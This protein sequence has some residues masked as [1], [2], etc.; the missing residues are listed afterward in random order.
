MSLQAVQHLWRPDVAEMALNPAQQFAP[1]VLPGWNCTPYDVQTRGITWL[2]SCPRSILGDVTGLGKTI[3]IFGLVALLHHTGE[4]RGQKA[5]V[6][7]EAVGQHL[8]E[9]R[10]F[11]P[12]IRAA[13]I[14]PGMN[15][16]ERRRIY[17]GEWDVLVIGYH[18]M[19]RDADIITNLSPGL[20]WFDE[21]TAF[22]NDETA[23]ANGARI[24]ATNARR[25]HL[26]TATPVMLGLKDFYSQLR[27]IGLAGYQGSLFGDWWSFERNF[28]TVAYNQTRGK[29][30]RPVTTTSW[31]A[32]PATLPTFKAR[33][34]SFYLRRTEG[35]ADMPAVLPPD[36]VWCNPT[37]A[38][39]DRLAQIIN[40]ADEGAVRWQLLFKG[41][42]TIAAIGGPDESGKFDRFMADLPIRFA[43]PDGRPEKIVVYLRHLASVAALERRLIAAGI[44][45]AT[46]TGPNKATRDAVRHRFWEDDSCRVVIGTGAIEKSLNL[47]VARHVAALDLVSNPSR[48]EQLLGRVRR[49]GSDHTHVTFTRYLLWGSPEER[50]LRLA[51]ERQGLADYIHGDMSSLFVRLAPADQ[52][53]VLGAAA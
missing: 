15:K 48:Q 10:R 2:W 9:C 17:A 49:S 30:G 20:V 52:S 53:Y 43:D 14:L 12:G 3:H 41:S 27:V 39:A 50:L 11:L 44:G 16:L 6:V 35:S 23:T 28:L 47:Q 38:Q 33:L 7:V 37:K 1:L 42:T 25:I 4:L 36:D 51:R 18:I 5:I 46:I 8:E 24:L 32:N 40:G 29:G 21:S 31:A 45:V 13:A 26:S 19:W 34:S 22:A